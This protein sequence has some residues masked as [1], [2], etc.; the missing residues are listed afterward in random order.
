MSEGSLF[1]SGEGA[2]QGALQRIGRRLNELGIPYAVAGGMALFQHG[3]RR[4]TEDVDILVTREGLKAIHTA[5]DGRGYVRP[6]EKSKNLRD[7]ES[8]VKI[9]FLLAGDY[10]GD[11]KP[12]DVRFP[13]PCAVAIDRD[14]IK[15]VNL[16]TLV[17]LKL[18]S[19]MTGADRMKDLADVQEL[20]KLLQLPS[21]FEADLSDSV[22]GQYRELWRSV[23]ALARRYVKL[24]RPDLMP[25][26]DAE[27][28]LA[29]MQADGITVDDNRHDSAGR[30][31]S[32]LVTT[33]PEA[34]RKYGLQDE[35]EYWADE[36]D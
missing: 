18:A 3:Y 6:F 19:G 28:Q 29:A 8:G 22:R 24:W 14:G 10:P 30:R 23:H 17:E 35:S 15:Y 9:E 16:P 25:A 31:L 13:D 7:A 26:D 27:R 34:A 1:F 33:D 32:Y 12:K 36:D 11:G 2:V 21:G 20:I 4:F 5:L